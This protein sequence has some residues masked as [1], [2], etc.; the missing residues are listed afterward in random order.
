M[1]RLTRFDP[2]GA[3]RFEAVWDDL[4]P[5]P[6]PDGTMLPFAF[7]IRLRF[8]RVEAEAAFVFKQVELVDSLDDG[9][10]V[11]RLADSA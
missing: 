11:L 9:L 6:S 10:F 4:R 7:E 1:R 5:L 8:P 2:Q 3:L